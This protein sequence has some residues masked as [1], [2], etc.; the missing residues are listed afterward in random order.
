MKFEAW[1]I[2]SFGPLTNWEESNLAESDVLIVL[3]PNES[4]KSSLFEF[5]TSALFGFSPA[6]AQKHPYRPWS[7]AFPR[8]AVDVRLGNGIRARVTRRL[9]SRPEG[10]LSI[11]GNEQDLGNRSVP[12]VGLLNRPI[13]TNVHALTQD[14]AL[15]LAPKAWQA[16][17]DRVLGGSSFDFLRPSREVMDE[18]RSRRGRYWRPDRRGR[19]RDREVRARILD[20]KNELKPALGRRSRI[21]EIEQRLSKIQQAL[22]KKGAQLESIEVQLE[23]DVRLSPLLRQVDRMGALNREADALVLVDELGTGIVK[24]REELKS[25]AIDLRKEF[26]QLE[27]YVHQQEQAQELTEVVVGLLA[28]REAIERLDRFT[29]RVIEDQNRVARMDRHLQQSKGAL[30]ELAERI[31]VGGEVDERIEENVAYLSIAELRGRHRTWTNGYHAAQIERQKWERVEEERRQSERDLQGDGPASSYET[32]DERLQKLREI[33]LAKATKIQPRHLLMLGLAAGGVSIL[34]G[35][36]LLL[37]QDGP[38]G[39]ALVVAGAVVVIGGCVSLLI[40][41]MAVGQHSSLD[42]Q[43]DDEPAELKTEIEDA[44]TARDTALQR[45]AL[46]ERYKK[47]E[48]AAVDARE[49]SDAATTATS[50]AA[51]QFIELVSYLPVAPVF[52]DKP[53][54]ALLRDLEEIRRTIQ[55][56]R[57]L[58]DDRAEVARRIG[59]WRDEG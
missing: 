25:K 2:E 39:W 17:Q 11:N 31:F 46:H 57:N 5:L 8:G 44:Q 29:E 4:G 32:L 37:S 36:V 45:E 16:M 42:V 49:R 23:R 47:L 7:G 26:K 6:S 53:D 48:T 59:T 12:W 58:S 15:A 43:R 20:L 21:E 34:A 10:R 3:G 38:I 51:A 18:L 55:T 33:Q 56:E 9:T 41:R 54:E 22:R 28:Q 24:Q 50:T 1:R 19:P 27:A 35:I 13:F 14:E 30:R 40:H 52:L